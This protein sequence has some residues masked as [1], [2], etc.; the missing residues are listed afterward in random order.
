MNEF[1][2]KLL[3]WNMN[4]CWKKE[5]YNW[6]KFA[7]ELM[8]DNFDFILLQEINPFSV[9]GVNY[10]IENGPVYFFE[11]ANKNIYYHELSEILLNERQ[12]DDF[13]GTAIITKK[14]IKKVK[15]YFYNM[16]NEYIGLNYFG[17]TAL[18]CYDF[19]L[20]NG[21]IIT[22]INYYKKGDTCKGKY[23]N[24]KCINLD[25]VYRYEENFFF[26][27]SHIMRNKNIIIFAGD[28]NVTKRIGYDYDIDGIIK[29][30]E[31]IGFTNKTK[32][33]GSSMVKYDNQ[34]DYIFVNN[35]YSEFVSDGNKI[36]PPDFIDHFGIKCGIKI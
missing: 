25:V 32:H 15:T 34:N 3:T 19:E 31:K 11:Y 4:F 24:G 21:N 28:F 12:D 16:H 22:I 20:E 23:K 2:L 18:M 7:C 14:N 8:K 6:R 17:N 27:I 13:W 1:N 10:K 9:F 30:I 26:D 29:K 33:I 36:S 5:N 35:L